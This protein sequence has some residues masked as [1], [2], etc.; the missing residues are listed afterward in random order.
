MRHSG[1]FCDIEVDAYL[2]FIIEENFHRLEVGISI[3]YWIHVY[4]S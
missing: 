3:P 2:F 1:K 4:G